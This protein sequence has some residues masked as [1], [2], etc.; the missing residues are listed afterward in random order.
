[1]EKWYHTDVVSEELQHLSHLVNSA[2][3]ITYTLPM[4]LFLCHATEHKLYLRKQLDLLLIEITT[5]AAIFEAVDIDASVVN[6]PRVDCKYIHEVFPPIPQMIL[7][8]NLKDYIF[9]TQQ[10]KPT[11]K[12][13][14]DFER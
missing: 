4:L 8:K 1:M 5:T 7:Q 3:L 2:F 13:M 6:P 10:C 11:V 9:Y 14:Y 12:Y